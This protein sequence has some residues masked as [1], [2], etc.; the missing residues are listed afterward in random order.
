MNKFI[1]K[2]QKYWR[3]RKGRNLAAKLYL[4][5]KNKMANKI[6]KM[7]LIWKFERKRKTDY[8]NYVHRMAYRIQRM[9]RLKTIY[10]I[11]KII[12]KKIEMSKITIIQKI[13]RSYL[14]RKEIKLYRKEIAECKIRYSHFL[15]NEMVSVF[16]K[17]KF[18]VEMLGC[19]HEKTEK[20]IIELILFYFVGTKRIE[21]TQNL[22][23]F[24]LHKYPDS[25]IGNFLFSWISMS[26][27]LSC[28]KMGL[29]NDLNLQDSIYLFLKP[30]NNISDLDFLFDMET[31]IMKVRICLLLFILFY[32]IIHFFTWCINMSVYYFL[33]L[34]FTFIFCI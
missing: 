7:F 20:E 22:V 24:L 28:E 27:W 14:S 31:I 16:T 6:M 13:C 21:I 3:G 34:F 32:F 1:I 17:I 9:Y 10:K 11:L 15:R 8:V 4:I 12:R 33:H 5:L 30:D 18:N 29:K 19:L 25:K 23:L 2:I 26:T